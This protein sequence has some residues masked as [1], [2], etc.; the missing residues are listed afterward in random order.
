MLLV[1]NPAQL[2][3]QARDSN[4]IQDL[5]TLSEALNYYTEDTASNGTPSLGSANIVYPSLGD[6]S[7]TSTL[8]DACQG[9]GMLPLPF[10]YSY[11]CAAP[12]NYRNVNGTGWVP[13]NFSSVSIGSPIS[14]LP[15]DPTDSSSSRLYYTYTTNGSQYELTAAMESAKYQL[16]GPSDAVS[17]DGGTDAYLYEKGTN[18]ALAPVDYGLSSGLVGYWPLDEGTGTVAYDWS[19]SNATGTWNG[20]ASGT[21][22]YYSAGSGQPYAGAFDGSSTYVI[23]PNNSV[24]NISGAVTVSAWILTTT[25]EPSYGG[26]AVHR[27]SGTNMDYGMDV[28]GSSL[29]LRF[30]YFNGSSWFDQTAGTAS[31]SIWHLY[32]VTRSSGAGSVIAYIDGVQVGSFAG[33]GNAQALTNALI[34]GADAG[35][36]QYFRGLIEDVRIYNTALSAAQI[37]LLYNGGK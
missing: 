10:S 8:G 19:G 28:T 16:G 11:R 2:L 25:S 14:E 18:L 13:V 1:L 24:L 37:A 36:A 33:I 32:T 6:P 35:Q 22:G 31:L 29:Q 30:N 21:S 34:L 3:M 17:T 26:I 27:S 20:N 4:R 7:A 12:A 15:V 9:L 5:A 23:V